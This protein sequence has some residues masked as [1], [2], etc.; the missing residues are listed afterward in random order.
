LPAAAMASLPDQL[1]LPDGE[2][3]NTILFASSEYWQEYSLFPDA[4]LKPER[5][6]IKSPVDNNWCQTSEEPLVLRSLA[7]NEKHI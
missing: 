4:V 3:K 6:N 7:Q 5:L 2:T 1:S